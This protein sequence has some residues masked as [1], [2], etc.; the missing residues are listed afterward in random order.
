MWPP[1]RNNNSHIQYIYKI[2]TAELIYQN[3][4][5]CRRYISNCV[6]LCSTMSISLI[7]LFTTE[8]HTLD[9]Q[10]GGTDIFH[11]SIFRFLGVKYGTHTV[12]TKSVTKKGIETGKHSGSCK[13]GSCVRI[14][15]RRKMIKNK[16]KTVFSLHSL[17]LK[18]QYKRCFHCVK[19]LC[20]RPLNLLVLVEMP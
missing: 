12:R 16:H 15:Q 19:S 20:I 17:F 18:G 7:T 1:L 6:I 11:D 13:T 4:C 9:H 2:M 14:L 10:P 8:K 5:C 3:Y